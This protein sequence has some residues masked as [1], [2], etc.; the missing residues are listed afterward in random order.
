MKVIDISLA[1]IK[2][3]EV[4]LK[5]RGILV[6]VMCLCMVANSIS[7]SENFNVVLNLYKK[8]FIKLLMFFLI[9]SKVMF[10]MA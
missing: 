8:V 7:I 10:S 3:M 5:G 9:V 6:M 4:F 1:V 2:L